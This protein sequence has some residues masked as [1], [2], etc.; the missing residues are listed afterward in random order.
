MRGRN[1]APRWWDRRGT[2]ATQLRPAACVWSAAASLR[3]RWTRSTE[4][5]VPVV[6]IGNLSIGGTGKTPIA[7]ATAAWMIQHGRTPHVLTRGYGGSLSATSTEPVRVDPD[8]HGAREAGDEPL[9]LARVAPVWICGDRVRSARA[10]IAAGADSLIMDDGFQNPGLAKHF[11][12]IAVDG[13]TGFGNELTLPAGPLREPVR[14]G[15]ARAHAVAVLGADLHN[16]RA[17]IAEIRGAG[18]PIL[19]GH[20]EP[21]PERAALNGASVIAFAGIGRPQKFFDTV[22]ACGAHL[23]ETVP[24]PDHHLFRSGEIESLIVQAASRNAALVTTE[25]DAVRLPRDVRRAV[26][27]LSVQVR[28]DDPDRFAAILTHAFAG[29]PAPFSLP[30]D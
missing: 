16:T 13:A 6:C 14:T 11:S 29:F 3:H 19:T 25:K 26:T 21:G 10:A 22:A 20:L 18:F 23:I 5:G 15:L 30:L 7:L 12:L 24:F 4:V 9:L 28:W 17:R 1:V 27:V 2:T 8:R